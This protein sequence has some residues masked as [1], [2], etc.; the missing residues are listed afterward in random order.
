MIPPT[1]FAI[2]FIYVILNT[3]DLCREWEHQNNTAPLFV[4]R[5]RVIGTIVEVLIISVWFPLTVV[6]LF[7][8]EDFK[9]RFFRVLKIAFIFA[10]ATVIY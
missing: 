10:E 4:I 2:L 6:I 3:A 1:A 9:R 8:W 5:I 7:G